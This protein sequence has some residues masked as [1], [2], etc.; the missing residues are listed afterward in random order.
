VFLLASATFSGAGW[1]ATPGVSFDRD[2]DGRDDPVVVSR[3][4]CAD[5]EVW[6]WATA[7]LGYVDEPL[8]VGNCATAFAAGDWDGDGRADQTIFGETTVGN[9]LWQSRQTT[10][11]LGRSFEFGRP[12]DQPFIGDFDGDGSADAAVVRRGASGQDTEWFVWLSPPYGPFLQPIVWGNGSFSDWIAPA[13]Y[14]GDGIT[15][16][17]VA[18]RSDAQG[19]PMLQWWIRPSTGDEGRL[20]GAIRTFHYERWGAEG[21]TLV[22][23]DYMGAGA[24][25]I[26]VVRREASGILTWFIQNR[27]VD[28][29]PLIVDWGESA[30][31]VPAPADYDGDGLTD[32]AVWRAPAP[33]SDGQFWIRRSSDGGLTQL[34]YGQAGRDRLPTSGT[35]FPTGS[36]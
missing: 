4:E 15:D 22:P 36:A 32:I 1:A 7:T 24:A 8:W 18:R 14:D 28:G 21:D 19:P 34:I 5:P 35:V 16:L 30:T 29:A 12:A 11:G 13:D 33:S 23:G 9:L 25:Q 6:H 20:P 3:G 27:D 17:A 10:D 31:D 2:G 26:A